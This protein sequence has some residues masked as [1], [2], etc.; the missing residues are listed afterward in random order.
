MSL[1]NEFISYLKHEVEVHS[2][3][4]IGGQ[5]RRG[6]EVTEPWIRYR[7]QES[8]RNADRAV[9]FWKKQCAAGYADVLGAFDCSGLGMYW[10]QQVKGI[11]PSDLNANGMYSK[12]STKLNKDQLKK[13]DWVFVDTDGRKTHIGYIVDD[14]LNVI[15]S[16]G[17]DY[18]VVIGK[19][20]KRWTHFGRPD[21]FKDEIE[22][23]ESNDMENINIVIKRNLKTGTSGDDVKALQKYLNR[24]GAGLS[25][26]G[27]FSTKTNN[28][29]IKF[30]K[31]NGLTVDGIAG[32]NTITK[33]DMI[34]GKD[35]SDEQIFIELNNLA[36]NKTL[37]ADNK[38]DNSD[39]IESLKN[40]IEKLN[41]QISV[42]NNE[43]S[44]KENDIKNLQN[45][46]MMLNVTLTKVN[47]EKAEISKNLNDS[48]EDNKVLNDKLNRIDAI[49]KE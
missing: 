32:K 9:N 6:K 5:G 21:V 16:R 10:L 42:L 2:I 47:E 11:F 38:V 20:D 19:L 3:Y 43:I 4:V 22:G 31:E 12:C 1:L 18:G 25:G 29:V 46:V 49:V 23:K 15:E 17:R 8:Q 30:Q 48:L 14:E 28:A 36:Y 24:F 34:W 39:E 41:N 44:N 40:Q 27:T 45:Q 33:L 13:G 35:K 37:E 26:T 7:E